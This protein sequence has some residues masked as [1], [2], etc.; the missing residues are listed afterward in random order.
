VKYPG[1]AVPARAGE[2]RKSP[3]DLTALP[4]LALDANDGEEPHATTGHLAVDRLGIRRAL[5]AGP[6][7][8]LALGGD[9]LPAPADV[10]AWGCAR[11]DARISATPDGEVLMQAARARR[12][13]ALVDALDQLK[14]SDRARVVAAAPV[15]GRVAELVRG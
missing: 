12:I 3:L 9:R 13:E 14:A 11:H 1:R 7:E 10:A 4:V 8:H 15:L 5:R 2:V 6:P